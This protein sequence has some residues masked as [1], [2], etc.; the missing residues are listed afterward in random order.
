MKVN[1][2]ISRGMAGRLT[3][4]FPYDPAHV[5]RSR[6]LQVVGGILMK[7]TGVFPILT[8]LSKNLIYLRS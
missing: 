3:V 5:T 6:L 8:V 2:K 4:S 1:I 7:D